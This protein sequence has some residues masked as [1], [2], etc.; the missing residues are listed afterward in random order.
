MFHFV[1]RQEMCE[2]Y[3]YVASYR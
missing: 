1:S 2:K 3:S